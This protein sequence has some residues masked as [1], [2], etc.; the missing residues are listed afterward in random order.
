MDAR[1]KK[2]EAIAENWDYWHHRWE[3]N[4]EGR[5]LDPLRD[6]LCG[7][8]QHLVKFARVSERETMTGCLECFGVSAVADIG[9]IEIRGS[10]IRWADAVLDG[11]EL[12]WGELD[13][14]IPDVRQLPTVGI[15]LKEVRSFPMIGR[16]VDV[17]WNALSGGENALRIAA[18][19]DSN[20]EIRQ[21][22]IATGSLSDD[23][24]IRSCTEHNTWW[25]ET[26]WVDPDLPPSKEKW[27][28]YEAIAR[29]L[30]T[31]PLG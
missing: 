29:H 14:G 30:L 1:W 8:L 5:P 3:T 21:A 2:G 27:V 19:L 13:Y 25:I 22:I 20:Q 9:F 24:I 18:S 10:P 4:L 15:R 17:R 28:L 31:L 16:I 12:L 26:L 6:T 23:P 7:H 11:N